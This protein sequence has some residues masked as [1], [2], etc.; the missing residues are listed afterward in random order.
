MNTERSLGCIK[1]EKGK[2]G[3]CDYFRIYCA[4]VASSRSSR[5]FT[6]VGPFWA[7]STPEGWGGGGPAWIFM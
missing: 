1:E 6:S 7:A 3:G 4:L 2:K 5:F